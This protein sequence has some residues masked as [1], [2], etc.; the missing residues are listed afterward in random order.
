MPNPNERQAEGGHKSKRLIIEAE[1]PMLIRSNAV[2]NFFCDLK[3]H[4]LTKH[5]PC[6]RI[7]RGCGAYTCGKKRRQDPLGK[8][9]KPL[10]RFDVFGSGRQKFYTHKHAYE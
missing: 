4:V 7:N 6:L 9:N 8:H 3:M 1:K 10:L 5:K 2:A